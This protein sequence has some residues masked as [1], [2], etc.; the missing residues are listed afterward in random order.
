MQT[1][2]HLEP[3][4]TVSGKSPV[5]DFIDSLSGKDKR[6]VSFSLMLLQQMGTQLRMPHARSLQGYSGLFELRCQHGSNIQRILY[7]HQIGKTFLLL[8]G[9]T[10]K[11]QKTPISDINLALERFKDYQHRKG[12][13]NG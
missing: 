12:S 10:K 6:K 8:H 5:D 4:L 9:F 1:E 3:Y 13:N 2:W 7:V 11:T